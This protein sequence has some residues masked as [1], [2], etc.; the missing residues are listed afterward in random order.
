M[1]NRRDFLRNTLGLGAGLAAAPRLFA[2]PHLNGPGIDMDMKHTSHAKERSNSQ[3]VW[4][5]TPDVLQLPWRM[6]GNIKEFHL[7]AEP[8]KQEIF[9]GRTVDLWGYNGS[10]PGPT[11]QVNQGDR[12]RIIVDNHLP[13]ATSMHWHG[14]EIPNEMDGAPGSSQDPIPPGGRFV[15]EFTLQQEGTY[16]YHSHMAMQEM[17]GMIGAFIMHPRESYKPRADKDFAIIMQEYAILPN[18]KVPNSMNMEFNWLT[19]NGKAGPATTPLIVRHGER[20]RI[21]LINL[22]MDH[23][24]I[25]LHGHQFVVTGTEGG[26]QPQSTW[27]PGNTVLVGVAQSRDVEFVANNPGDWMLHCHLPHHMM[28]QMSS[29]VG[30]MSRR[31]GMPAGLDMENGMGMLREG[32]V[33]SEENGPSL[34]RGMGVGSTAEQTVSNSP[35]KVGNPMPHQDMPDMQPRGMQMGKP[36]ISKEGNSVP[37]FPQD[38]FM[39]GPTMAM[40]QMVDKPENFGLR[41]GWSGFMAGMMTFVRVLPQDK[42]DQIMELRKKQ[43]GND[44]MKMEMPGME[45]KHE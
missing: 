15:Y 10:A 32:S 6:D 22:G 13:E 42:Y 45:H 30:L 14:F 40:D 3:I 41:P 34:G 2:A 36:E 39:E 23:H 35:L 19:L 17:M 37:G 31:N 43:E 33:T 26:R 11:I 20:V 21:R 18:I 1:K 5:E 8:V 44:P 4:V 25:H 24:P 16:F 38:A 9:P 28:N 12:V 7:V 27:G 29:M